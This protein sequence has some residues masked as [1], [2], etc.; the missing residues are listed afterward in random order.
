METL[1]SYID[2]IIPGINDAWDRNKISDLAILSTPEAV[3]S[4]N[5]FLLSAD[6]KFLWFSWFIES[7]YDYHKASE[8]IS[9]P[10]VVSSVRRGLLKTGFNES[11]QKFNDVWK[12]ISRLTYKLISKSSGRSREHLTR[13]TKYDLIERSKGT[14]YCWICGHRFSSESIDKFSN[15]DAEIKLPNLIDYFLQKGLKERD[16][17]IEVEH[18]MPFI[19]GGGD[20][21]DL[22]NIELCCGFC[23]RYKW[24]F[25]SIYDANR[26]LKTFIHPRIGNISI[27][28]PYWA[29]RILALAEGCSEPTCTVKKEK[30][31][32]Y[33][34]L[35]NDIGS[36]TPTN[37]K[38]VCKK[39][40]KNKGDRFLD[41]KL[42]ENRNT[43]RNSFI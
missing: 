17:K 28:Q 25:I 31:A 2:K 19:S 43:N 18:K 38:V 29:I 37:L 36:A 22:N 42:F 11:D 20:L 15:L 10:E 21:S 8:D 3:L 39:H 13:S 5:S 6:I 41:R 34:D 27:P 23:N 4:K 30:A 26:S 24:K 9:Y 7:I 40:L 12:S 1:S 16:F 14:P 35:I 33:V 32:L